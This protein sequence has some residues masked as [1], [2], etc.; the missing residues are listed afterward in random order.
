VRP[1]REP[2]LVAV[3]SLAERNDAMGLKCLQDRCDR[4]DADR[5][6]A[7]RWLRSDGHRGCARE[8]DTNQDRSCNRDRPGNVQSHALCLLD[9]YAMKTDWLSVRPCCGGVTWAASFARTSSTDRA[10]P[11]NRFGRDAPA[12]SGTADS[13]RSSNTC[14]AHLQEG[15]RAGPAVRGR[16]AC[17]VLPSRASRGRP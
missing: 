5:R 11:P 9:A 4:I 15:T 1:K 7:R 12:Q 6:A 17:P 2:L 16:R 13:N 14:P 8:G 3:R 10:A